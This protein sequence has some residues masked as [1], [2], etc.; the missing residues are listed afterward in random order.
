MVGD[1]LECRG[2]RIG[3]PNAIFTADMARAKESI[4]RMAAL[5]FE[6]LCFSHFAPIRQGAGRMLREFAAAL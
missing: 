4:R 5:D 6:V 3:L 1:A 2:G